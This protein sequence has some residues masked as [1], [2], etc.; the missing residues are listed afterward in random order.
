MVDLSM[1]SNHR[2]ILIKDN[3]DGR[4]KCM[5]AATILNYTIIFNSF[6]TAGLHCV[7]QKKL[8]CHY[9]TGRNL[10]F[11]VF[12]FRLFVEKIF[13]QFLQLV[14]LRIVEAGAHMDFISCITHVLGIAVEV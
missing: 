5:P 10:F 4:L 12:F 8:V 3:T 6:E 9:I 11:A 13:I 1:V 14:F 2:E 7:G